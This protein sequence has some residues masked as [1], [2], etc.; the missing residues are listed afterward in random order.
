MSL[1]M[2][3]EET[4]MAE[5]MFPPKEMQEDII[6]TIEE[7]RKEMVDKTPIQAVEF[8]EGE[9]DGKEF[10]FACYYIGKISGKNEIRDK[11]LLEQK[12]DEE[13]KVKIYR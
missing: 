10:Y 7:R 6:D 8:A 12:L 1:D 5:S 4:K 2:S 3:E 13:E 11:C 9:Y